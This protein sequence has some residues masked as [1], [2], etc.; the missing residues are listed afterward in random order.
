MG[1]LL[2]IEEERSTTGARPG[3]TSLTL[4]SRAMARHRT[5][6]RPGSPL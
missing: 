4:A 3:R 6:R 5:R 1:Y 2:S